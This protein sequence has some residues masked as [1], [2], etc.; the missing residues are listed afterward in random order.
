MLERIRRF[1][2]KSGWL[3]LSSLGLFVIIMIILGI[4]AVTGYLGHAMGYLEDDFFKDPSAGLIVVYVTSLIIGLI[5]ILMLNKIILKPLREMVTAMKELADGNFNIRVYYGGFFRPWEL[6]DFYKSFN[7]AAQELSS[8][9]MLRKDFVNDFSHEFKTPIVSL[10]GFARLLKEGNL[11]QA[12]TEEYLGIIVSESDRLA[13]LATNVLNLAKIETQTILAEKEKFNISEDIRRSVLMMESKWSEKELELELE[14]EELYYYGNA[15][16]LHQVWVNILDN[17][18]KFS[19][20]SSK[21]SIE[22]HDSIDSVIF[23]VQDYGPGMDEMTLRK[24]FDKFYQQD[25]SRAT[26]GNGL[27]LTIVKKILSLHHGEIG[28]T[29][30]VGKGTTV[31]VV[32]P[33]QTQ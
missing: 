25:T 32:L 10:G 2:S 20:Q 6:N 17:A 19:P 8:I 27:G 28:V 29:S 30:S 31:T 7:I 13:A 23:K 14:I 16:L 12:E 4:I 24:M 11:S 18:V 26:E 1:F 5:T 33:K 15:E 21:L 9:E 22:L 3:F